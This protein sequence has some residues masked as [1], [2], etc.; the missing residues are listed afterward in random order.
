VYYQK[1][2]A[3][4][5]ALLMEATGSDSYNVAVT[6][7][8]DRYGSGAQAAWELLASLIQEGG[9]NTEV[10]Y[11]EYGSYIQSAYLGKTEKGIALGPLIG[12]PRD[13]NDI[14]SRNLESASPRHNWSGTPID[15]MA[16]IDADIAKQ[17]T[18]LEV[19][20][21]VEFIHEMQRKMAESHLIV[22]YHGGA[23]YGYVQ[24]WVQNYHNKIGYAVYRTSI[25]KAWFTE[26]R[27]A[28]G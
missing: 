14:Y 13:P 5:K 17:R 4:A 9:F 15:E 25:A 10:I 11:Q 6:S 19:E 23:G 28:R 26:D 16:E 18:I 20:E 8:V 3:K 27:I 7:N 21:R 24:P 1:D 12:S 2:T 22:P